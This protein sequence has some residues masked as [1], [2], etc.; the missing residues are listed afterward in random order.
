M[1]DVKFFL[2]GMGAR[3]KLLY[4]DGMLFDAKSGRELQ[5]WNVQK[6]IIMP[7]DYSVSLETEDGAAL[8]LR[9]DAEA[10]WLELGGQRMAVEG[11]KSPV[12]SPD[13]AGKKFPLVLRVPAGRMPATCWVPAVAGDRR[14]T[15]GQ[16]QHPSNS[17]PSRHP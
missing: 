13:F 16:W 1:P 11:T 2:F 8:T 4:R 15:K 3:T 7:P 17:P 5:R 9:E 14:W 12:K 6:E 10:V